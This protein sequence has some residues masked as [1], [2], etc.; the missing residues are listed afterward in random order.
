[1]NRNLY[2]RLHMVL[3]AV[4]LPFLL[5]MPL[6]GG[7]Y[8]LGIKGSQTKTLAFQVAAQVP[9]TTGEQEDFFRQLFSQQGIDFDFEYIRGSGPDFVFRPS[10]RDH[11]SAR[12]QEGQV[13]VY[14]LEPDLLASL[15]E[16]HKGH[17]PTHVKWL[18]RLFA[19]GL[20]LITFSGV[21]LAS[22]IKAYRRLMFS[23][24]LIGF[25]VAGLAFL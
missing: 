20:L 7:L 8:L 19:L 13:S 2:I 25:V 6:S 11:F 22:Q 18:Q 3:A 23:G 15:M 16:I 17:G 4:F 21:L 9:E 12:A 1:M 14:K 24:I 10:S 5:L